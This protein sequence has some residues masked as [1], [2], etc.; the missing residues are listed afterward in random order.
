[1]SQTFVNYPSD[2][3]R[4]TQLVSPNGGLNGSAAALNASIKA[5]TDAISNGQFD[6]YANGYG[7][8]VPYRA[9]NFTGISYV[10]AADS[11]SLKPASALTIAAWIF[12]TAD[13]SATTHAIVSKSLGSWSSPKYASYE[14]RLNGGQLDGWISDSSYNPA[15]ST[16]SVTLN[17]WNFVAM[18]Y[19]GMYT[20]FYIN[21]GTPDSSFNVGAHT[22]GYN[23][24]PLFIGH[25]QA[26]DFFQG[27]LAEVQIFDT[28][29]TS[30][31]IGELWNGGAGTYT[32]PGGIPA[33]NLMAWYHLNG[34]AADYS[35]NSNNGTWTGEGYAPGFF[36]G[37]LF[38]VMIEYNNDAI[39]LLDNI[40]VTGKLNVTALPSGTL[41][42]PP[43]GLNIG[44]IWQD[45]T[46][47]TQYPMLRVRAS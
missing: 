44:D 20:T 3:N 28:P 30:A 32:L 19:D 27:K 40:R 46:S 23:S 42:S 35:G 17:Q 31:Q 8:L 43:A 22:I 1:M 36:P 12:P 7:F 4:I 14:L 39:Q 15:T 41:A 34:D 29:L 9:G 33:G 2:T 38:A 45:T 13:F 26:P 5:L 18:V 24:N 25:S 47:S 16:G 6:I 11:P 21:S 37:T 10:S